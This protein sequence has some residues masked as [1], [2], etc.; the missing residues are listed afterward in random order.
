MGIKDAKTGRAGHDLPNPEVKKSPSR[1]APEGDVCRYTRKGLMPFV[2]ERLQR[3]R[4]R[5]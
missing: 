1:H 2:V 4:D 3:D 5:G